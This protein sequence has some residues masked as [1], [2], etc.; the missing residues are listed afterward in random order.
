MEKDMYN[1][2]S[3]RAYKYI[4]IY[5]YIHTYLVLAGVI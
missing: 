4:Y 1:G 5:M 2:M 3:A